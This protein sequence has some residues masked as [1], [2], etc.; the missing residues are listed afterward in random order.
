MR[1]GTRV[2][3]VLLAEAVALGVAG[4]FLFRGQAIGANV[5]LWVALFVVAVLAV[6]RTARSP[7][8][9]GRRLMVLPLGAA[10]ILLVWHDSPLLL[11]ANT[12]AAAAAVT[13][14]ALRRTRHPLRRTPLSEYGRSALSAAI[15]T[16]AG[17]IP[18]LHRDVDWRDAA[19]G[20]RSGPLPAVARGAAIGVPFV[21]LF[22]GLFVAADAVFSNLVTGA[23]PSFDQ[24][25]LQVAFVGGFA[26]ASGGLLRDLA[27]PRDEIRQL[28]PG[29]LRARVPR[30]GAVEVGIV[31]GALNVLFLAFVLVQLRYLFGGHALVEARTRL[32]YAEYA[33][34]GFFELVAVAALV[35]P[36]VLAADWILRTERRRDVVVVRALSAGLIALVLVVMASALQRM[37][38]YEQAYGLTELRIYATGI[39]I[40]LG[41]VF[42]WF[43]VTVLRGRRAQFPVG[44]LVL[45]F[46]ATLALNALNP[47][48]VIARTNLDRPQVDVQYVAHLSDDA[49]PALI[50]RLPR[51]PPPL[52]QQLTRELL[53][54][55]LPPT[56]WRSWNVSRAHARS[57]LVAHRAELERYAAGQ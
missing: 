46:A 19:A 40:W 38:L 6:V 8:H 5:A 16:L 14:G 15:A 31:L 25:V 26:W 52:R 27:A 33:R 12:V 54:R 24:P 23:L 44:V 28:P 21:L 41:A 51:L 57:A 7:F 53:A 36:L 9:Q 47:D 29:D 20:S 13:L 22:G 49:V 3:L 56:G 37:R 39:I 45:G 1:D 50:A 30:L 43:A 34:H 18:V 17:L 10:A 4:D 11:A 32:T 35:L 55:R 42:G 2:G 48:A